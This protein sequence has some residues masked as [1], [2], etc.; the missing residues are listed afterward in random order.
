MSCVVRRD[1]LIDDHVVPVVL[2]SLSNRASV[3]F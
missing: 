3:G 1:L 2:A